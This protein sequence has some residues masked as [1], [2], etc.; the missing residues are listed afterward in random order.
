MQRQ[1]AGKIISS[2]LIMLLMGCSS[3]PTVQDNR[4]DEQKANADKAHKELTQ[5]VKKTK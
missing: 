4:A 2:I 5:E 3:A 1:L